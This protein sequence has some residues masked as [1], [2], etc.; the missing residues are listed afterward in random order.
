MFQGNLLTVKLKHKMGH[1]AETETVETRF[2]FVRQFF[3]YTIV[4]DVTYHS[5]MTTSR[6]PSPIS[7]NL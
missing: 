7:D 6:M 3:A 1:F 4:L 2:S 5:L